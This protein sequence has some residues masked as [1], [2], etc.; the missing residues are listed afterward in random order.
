M[1]NG[2]MQYTQDNRTQQNDG[3]FFGSNPANSVPTDIM[4]NDLNN[5]RPNLQPQESQE[6]VDNPQNAQE[7]FLGSFT[8]VLQNNIG[9]YVI[10]DFLIGTS[11]LTSREGILYSV[12]NNFVTLYQPE[13][14]Q[15][16]VCDAFSIKFVTFFNQMTRPRS[17]MNAQNGGRNGSSN[18]RRMYY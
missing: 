8:A 18:M 11:E 2:D 15:Y 10:I 17:R 5:T 9:Y 16:I 12:G 14:E 13:N 3:G 1:A 6:A 4:Q 7:A